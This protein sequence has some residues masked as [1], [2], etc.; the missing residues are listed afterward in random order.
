[1]R[2]LP[3]AIVILALTK[4]AGTITGLPFR[5]EP[6]QSTCCRTGEDPPVVVEYLGNGGIFLR[7]GDD[8]ILT[9]PFFSNPHLLRAGFLPIPAARERVLR[10]MHR[11][12]GLELVDVVLAGHGHYDHLLDLPAVFETLPRETRLYGNDTTVAILGRALHDRVTSVAADAG[13][14]H[15]PGRWTTVGNVRFMP[16]D[17][18]HAP[19]F[20]GL[21]FYGGEVP[22]SLAELPR[23]AT[24]WKEGKPLAF[25]LDFLRDGRID[26]RVYYNDSAHSSPF[27]KPDPATLAEHCVDLAIVTV[28]SFHEVRNY[29]EWLIDSLRPRHVLLAHW[30]DFFTSSEA[31]ERAVRF[32]NVPKFV[33]RLA[34]VYPRSDTTIL[35]RHQRLTFIAPPPSP[36]ANR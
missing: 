26:F 22:T 34:A 3:A 16:I 11:V 20:H 35:H 13:N 29:P 24:G 7:R 33:E 30:D 25:L 5:S 2:L 36:T 31:G 27:G 10:H 1:M 32:T 4:C 15:K 28:A 9:A 14:D 8:A 19:H 17:T 6:V 21:K 12:E 23:R 18:E